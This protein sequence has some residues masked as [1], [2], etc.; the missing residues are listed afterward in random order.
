MSEA[1]PFGVESPL[2]GSLVGRAALGTFEALA[3]G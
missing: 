1:L 2:G 3:Q